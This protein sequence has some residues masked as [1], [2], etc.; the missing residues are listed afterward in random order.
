MI[1]DLRTNADAF[2][3]RQEYYR[4]VQAHGQSALDGLQG[5][6]TEA[7]EQ[8]LIHAYQ[9]SQIWQVSIN[10]AAYHEILSVGAMNT[11]P[12]IDA[13]S[14]V[15]NYYTAFDGISPQLNTLSAYRETIRSYI[16]IEIQR[17]IQ[18]HCGDTVSVDAKGAIQNQLSDKCDLN[19][20]ATTTSMAK[21]SLMIAPELVTQLTRRLADL[22]LKIAI[23]GRNINRSAELADYLEGTRP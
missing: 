11:I 3:A 21:D 10:Q 13:R 23:L 19:L 9:A 5:S 20:D 2:Q 17:S 6:Q 18:R 14:K 1:E 7:P 12:D 8:F 16:P 15:S 4:E 22:D